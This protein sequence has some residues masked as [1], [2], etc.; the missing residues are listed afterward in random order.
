MSCAVEVQNACRQIIV[1]IHLL[2]TEDMKQGHTN[3]K[4]RIIECQVREVFGP[5]RHHADQI[6]SAAGP[7]VLS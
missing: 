2:R 7:Y 6:R 1:S 5:C 4:M 3:M